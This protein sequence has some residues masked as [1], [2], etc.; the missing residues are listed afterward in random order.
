MAIKRYPGKIPKYNEII[1]TPLMVPV[2]AIIA[3]SPA[4]TSSKKG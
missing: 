4:I 2:G 1:I 3:T